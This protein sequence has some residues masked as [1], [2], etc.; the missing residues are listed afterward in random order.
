[1]VEPEVV[2]I[3]AGQLFRA[4]LIEHWLEI[5]A[6]AVLALGSVVAAWSANQASA[7]N[8]VQTV[9]LNQAA[10]K[11]IEAGKLDAR[12]QQIIIV[13]STTFNSYAEAVNADDQR[14]AQFYAR[15][16]RPELQVAVDAWVATDPLRNPDAPA[17]PLLMPEYRIDEAAQAEQML[18][19]SEQLGIV[20]ERADR[21]G[22][23]YTTNGFLTALA[24]FFAG[25][26][27]RFA[28]RPLKMVVVAVALFV[29][30]YATSVLFSYPV[31]P[32]IVSVE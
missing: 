13:D 24:L 4:R 2:R 25:I 17:S 18:A 20:G 7:W 30:I 23:A 29:L 1:M 26:A 28:W 19:E 31:Q 32:F 5:V 22:G 15:R 16:F 6:T 21:I 27:P 10:L 9:S 11:R 8:G 12:A 3:T 14:L